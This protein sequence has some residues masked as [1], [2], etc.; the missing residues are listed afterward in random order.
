[1]SELKRLNVRVRS[2]MHEWL[3]VQAEERGLS[4][5]AMV[6]LALETYMMQQQVIPN[7][8]GLLEAYKNLKNN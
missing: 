2:E 8:G 1:M 7:I 3:K 6:I 5:N 4:I